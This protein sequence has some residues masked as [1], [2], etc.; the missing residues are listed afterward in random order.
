MNQG[1]YSS[2]LLLPLDS[3]V[4]KSSQMIDTMTEAM[5]SS[6]L[7]V[8]KNKEYPILLRNVSEI[9]RMPMH[10]IGLVMLE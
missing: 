6:I 4:V 3:I 7:V 10:S 5:W 8:Q 9:I 2:L 1:Q